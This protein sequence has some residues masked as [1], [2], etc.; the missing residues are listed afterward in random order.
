MDGE[1]SSNLAKL[2]LFKQ[3]YI[4]IIGYLCLTRIVVFM[5]RTIVAYD[6]QWVSNAAEETASF[7]FFIVM[8]YMFRPVERNE[9]FVLD[10]KEEEA[11][12]SGMKV[13]V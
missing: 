13:S 8:F 3:F 10:E 5:L 4:V 6:Y 1:V 2:T 7:A 11:A 12:L 9:C